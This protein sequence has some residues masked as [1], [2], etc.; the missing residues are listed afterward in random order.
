MAQTSACETII[1]N[2]VHCRV[3]CVQHPNTVPQLW[4]TVGEHFCPDWRGVCGCLTVPSAT[5]SAPAATTDHG[6]LTPFT[7]ALLLKYR[8]NM[9][10]V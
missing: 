10:R 5:G 2:V 9:L 7:F 6:D 4:R 8:T 3:S 1:E